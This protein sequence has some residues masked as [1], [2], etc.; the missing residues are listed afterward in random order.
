MIG[1]KNVFHH[2]FP[3]N[4][5]VR[6]MV[7]LDGELYFAAG[8]SS[9][10][11]LQIYWLEHA[12]CKISKNLTP[13]WKP[14]P[15]TYDLGMAGF[16]NQLYIGTDA[17]QVYCID[18]Q[19]GMAS[20]PVQL[21]GSISDIVVHNGS[22]YVKASSLHCTPDGVNWNNLGLIRS[23]VANEV[24]DAGTLAAFKGY[25]YYGTGISQY[26]P[27]TP[28]KKIA[29]G[30]EIWRSPDG[31]KW[32]LFRSIIDDLTGLSLSYAPQHVHAMKEFNGY[33]YIGEYE[34]YG[35][36]V[37][38]TNGSIHSWEIYP[39]LPSGNI[40]TIEAHDGKL[41]AGVFRMVGGTAG[42]PLLY[43]SSN[44]TTWSAAPGSPVGAAQ[45]LGIVSMASVGGKLYYGIADTANGGEVYEMGDP[46]S[47]CRIADIYDLSNKTVFGWL[48][49]MIRDLSEAKRVNTASAKEALQDL[50][51]A[52]MELCI[53]PTAREDR[54]KALGYLRMAQQEL[55]TL[56]YQA[57]FADS[58]EAGEAQQVATRRAAGYGERALSAYRLY[59][60]ALE[61]VRERIRE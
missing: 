31:K 54:E 3:G 19:S 37:F 11:A 18:P 28:W 21:T 59:Q 5:E 47:E 42:T 53:G 25:L 58:L 44:G 2:P 32:T 4:R 45:T 33:L 61:D 36:S 6:R 12:G 43:C 22:L 39:A 29:Q 40:R 27:T 38:R 34:G 14:S 8:D 1:F 15:G 7:G 49:W 57:R 9:P 56:E 48:N 24:V 13:S 41:Y 55:N 50:D 51:H 46:L 20:V 17:G 26:D 30:I 16:Q 10:N 35:G 60:A 52:L 23:P